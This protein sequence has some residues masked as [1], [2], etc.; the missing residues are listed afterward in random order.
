MTLL[1]IP[2][3][4]VEDFRARL[5]RVSDALE[6][7]EQELA[8]QIVQDLEVELASLKERWAA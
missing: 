2:N 1:V 5:V 7:G 6:V 4:L 8:L 3:E